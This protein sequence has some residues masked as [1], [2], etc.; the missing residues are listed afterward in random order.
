MKKIYIIGFVMVYVFSFIGVFLVGTIIHENIHKL[1]LKEIEKD[2]EYTC[3]LS[4]EKNIGF[5][6]FN[7]V[8]SIEISEIEKMSE[9][10]AIVLEIIL[11]IIFTTAF[12]ITINY[13]LE[14]NKV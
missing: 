13:I 10:K 12:Y 1:D 6:L 14:H 5:Y 4:F 9:R 11:F 2:F 7:N 3:Y 8:R